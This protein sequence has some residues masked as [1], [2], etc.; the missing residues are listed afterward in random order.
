MKDSNFKELF[1]QAGSELNNASTELSKPRNDV[2]EYSVC[3][4]SRRAL[5]FLVKILYEFYSQKNDDPVKEHPTLDEM[6][7]YCVDYNEK[8]RFMNFREIYCRKRDVLDDDALFYCD[9]VEK[10][11]ACTE[12]AEK[13]KK[14]VEEVVWQGKDPDSE[15]TVNK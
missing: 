11:K 14:V 1:Q 5:Y 9:E 6:V 2:V 4:S 13:V 8:I 12:L 7:Q 3:V 15:N 10:V